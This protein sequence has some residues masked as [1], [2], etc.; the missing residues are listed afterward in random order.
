MMIMKDAADAAVHMHHPNEILGS[1]SSYVIN[2]FVM[3]GIQEH[4][5]GLRETYVRKEL[6]DA[7]ARRFTAQ[8]KTEGKVRTWKAIRMD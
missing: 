5:G 2:N 1:S 4:C 8:T 7:L 3:G 6:I